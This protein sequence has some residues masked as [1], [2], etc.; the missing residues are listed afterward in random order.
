MAPINKRICDFLIEKGQEKISQKQLRRSK[1]PRKVAAK[2][3]L[4]SAFRRVPTLTLEERYISLC[5]KGNEINQQ[6]YSKLQEKRNI[7][8][9]LI[10]LLWTIET[11]SYDQQ[12]TM[13]QIKASRV[14]W[15]QE[16]RNILCS[17]QNIQQ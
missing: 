10:R 16:S 14:N 17:S 2:R 13:M 5:I 7:E 9:E 11:N 6:F 8:Q 15:G 4:N 1:R 12:I 3:K